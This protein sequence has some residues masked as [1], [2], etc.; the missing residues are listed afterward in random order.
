MG[1]G[2][3]SWQPA[4]LRGLTPTN[5]PLAVAMQQ[6]ALLCSVQQQRRLDGAYWWGWLGLP[7]P[8]S[9]PFSLLFLF[10]LHP[11]LAF[12]NLSLQNRFPLTHRARV[13]WH[14]QKRHP[15]IPGV[16][17]KG[18]CCWLPEGGTPIQHFGFPCPSLPAFLPIATGLGLRVTCVGRCFPGLRQ[19]RSIGRHSQKL[20]RQCSLAH[21]PLPPRQGFLGSTRPRAAS[22]FVF[23]AHVCLTCSHQHIR[24][25]LARMGGPLWS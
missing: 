21:T 3:S 4:S 24:A 23:L 16:S 2:A 5:R 14:K 17:V 15:P 22:L 18:L 9:L 19:V 13:G 1:H 20:L 7:L 10:S 8:F 11:V 12:C 25:A 6:A